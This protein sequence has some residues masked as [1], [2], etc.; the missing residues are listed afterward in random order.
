MV[1]EAM[2]LSTDLEEFLSSHQLNRETNQNKEAK[3]E[4]SFL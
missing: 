1:T 4:I 2:F 3:Q